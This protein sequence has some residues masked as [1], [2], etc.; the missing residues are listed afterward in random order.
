MGKSNILIKLGQLLI[1]FGA[2]GEKALHTE[3]S[4][5]PPPNSAT[6]MALPN[7]ECCAYTKPKKID[8]R[9]VI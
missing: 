8:S 4:H 5:S 3:V 7:I 9:K 1:K 2:E 6:K